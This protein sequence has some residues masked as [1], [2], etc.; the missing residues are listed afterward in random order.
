MKFTSK[1]LLPLFGASVFMVSM[2]ALAKKP[3][4]KPGEIV[5]KGD[6]F[7]FTD[8][9]IVK[10]LPYSGYTVIKVAPGKEMAQLRRFRD[11][12]KKANLNF[13]INQFAVPNDPGY[14]NQWN[15]QA[16]QAENAWDVATG[17][18]VNVAVVDSGLA[19]GGSDGIN[20]V[21]QAKNTI[22][23]STNAFDGNGHGTHVSGT[24]AQA[25]NNN[26]GVAGLAYNAC[27]IPIKALNDSGSG[28]DADIAEAIAYA[29]DK[30]ARVINLSLGYPASYPLSSFA[31]S[32]SYSVLNNLADNVVVVAAS[33]NEGAS[34]VSYP[35]SHPKTIA[36]GSVAKGN[37]IASYSNRGPSLD[38]VAP[39]SGITQETRYNSTWNYYAYNGTSM[40]APHVSAAAALLISANPSLTFSDVAQKLKSSALDLGQTGHDAVYGAGLIQASDALV[41]IGAPVNQ[42][43]MASF[44]VSCDSDFLCT[45]TSQ[46]VDP[47]GYITALDWDFGNG[48]SI[49]GETSSSVEHQFTTSGDYAVTLTVT[50]NDGATRSTSELVTLVGA[51]PVETPTDV[52]AMDNTNG[53]ASIDWNYSNENVTHFEI[54]RRKQNRKGAWGGASLIAVLGSSNLSYTDAS[55]K[56]IFSYRVRSKN[57]NGAGEWSIW[58]DVTVTGGEKG[59]GSGGNN[60][61]G[62]GKKNK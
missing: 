1:Y 12:G 34:N 2:T 32:A 13:I 40:A 23:G 19:D 9:E 54:E 37:G 22:D 35:A 28:T 11:K 7:E 53:T 45:F 10:E 60:G 20:C 41:D 16:V 56:G 52:Q 38:V 47:D 3:I 55:G 61:P 44:E 18:D 6:V 26:V 39:G 50:D 48:Y 49:L 14:S 31:G 15:M 4:F 27:I 59:G 30:G 36:V 57:A 8:Y 42:V 21:I 29:A 62:K 25:T 58:V 51:V 43:P 5:V 17:Y 46:S 33:G 24:I